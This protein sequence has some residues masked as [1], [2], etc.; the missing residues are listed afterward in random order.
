MAILFA[1]DFSSP[2]ARARRLSAGEIKPLARGI[3][4]DDVDGDPETIVARGWRTILGQ[5][6]PGAVVTGRTAFAMRP[7]DGELF[8]SHSRRTPLELPGLTIYPDG[9]NDYRQSSDIPVDPSGTIFAASPVRALIDNTETRGRPGSVQRRLTRTELHDKIAHLVATST[10]RQVDQILGQVKADANKVA[11]ESVRVFVEAARGNITTVDSESRALNAAQ[12]GEAY[13]QARVAL[14][15][16]F[17]AEL[18]RGPIVDRPIIEPARAAFAPFYEAYFSNYIEGTTF[19]IEEARDVIYANADF[20]RPEDAHDVAATYQIVND[21]AEMSRPH[22]D[23]NDFLDALRERHATMMR[24][25]PDKLPGR[26]KEKRNQAGATV[27]V[28][29]DQVPGT[30]RAG[31]EEG[32]TLTDPFQ[33]AVYT[34]FMVSEV[35]PFAD[36]NGRSAR[37]AMNAELVPHDLQRIVI[38]TILRIEYLSALTRA[39]NGGGPRGLHRVLDYAHEWTAVAEFSNLDDGDRYLRVTRALE[40]SGVAERAGVRL[41]LLRP[42]EMWELDDQPFPRQSETPPDGESWVASAVQRQVR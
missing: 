17:I 34:T 32:L 18:R 25:H 13:D 30:L 23:A 41:V 29:P 9:S 5:V 33:R 19:T 24:A 42:G 27:F 10:P 15:K 22:R 11:A 39:T 26:W 7:V 14:F 20:G 36:G 37:V 16:N 2:S 1:G 8:V 31:Y 21:R 6:M 12:A 3:W 38:P 4:T 35:H 40:D 28:E